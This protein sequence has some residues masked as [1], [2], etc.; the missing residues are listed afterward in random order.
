MVGL[1][2]VDDGKR[3]GA[4]L[5]WIDWEGSVYSNTGLK[6]IDDYDCFVVMD[7]T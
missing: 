4:R 6:R 7:D 5:S 3:P 2:G 1:A